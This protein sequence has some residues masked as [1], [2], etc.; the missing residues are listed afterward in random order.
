MK[1][2]VLTSNDKRK[3]IV[4][5]SKHFFEHLEK[6]HTDKGKGNNSIHEENGYYF[7]VTN[8]FY[9]SI[10]DWFDKL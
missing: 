3:Y 2:L 9:K 5:N 7:T 4:K 6:F 1:K 8:D 10:V